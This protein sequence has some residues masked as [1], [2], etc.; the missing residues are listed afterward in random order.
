MSTSWQHRLDAPFSSQEYRSRQAR[1]QHL[2][3]ERELDALV[4]W[5]RGG[6]SYDRA[7]AVFWL[8]NYAS[9]ASG[10]EAVF[11]SGAIG[12]GYAALLVLAGREPEL[13]ISEPIEATDTDQIAVGAGAATPGTCPLE[14]ARRLTE[15][16]IKG[17][18]AY[19]GDDFLPTQFMRHLNEQAPQ[20]S[21]EPH[22]DIINAIQRIKS[23]EE[24]R[25]FRAAGEVASQALT[26]M[27]WGLIDAEPESTAA[28]KAAEI[29]TRAGGG[30]QRLST[31]HGVS[32]SI[33]SHG[34]Y[35]HR[36]IAAQ[37]GDM[38]RGWVMGPILHGL[39]LDPGRSAVCGNRPSSRQRDL[40]D[41][42]AAI[43]DAALALVRPGATPREIGARID[44][45]IAASA[46][47]ETTARPS[48]RSTATVWA[49]SSC[50]RMSRRGCPRRCR[51]LPGCAPTR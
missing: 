11:A 38:V 37:R 22:E 34:L 17:S 29:I 21:W 35:S 43:M 24:L 51:H 6:G 42:T 47:A 10:Q 3:S 40:L 49:R 27:M 46:C 15:L 12:R 45:A 26:A 13:H 39:W 23:A 7:G 8:C 30:F 44:D 36:P 41:N 50:P 19:F 33:W 48:G 28:A 32:P 20:I 9:M 16:G 14:S 1:L 18:V 5:Q 2:M 31:N 25:A 4:V